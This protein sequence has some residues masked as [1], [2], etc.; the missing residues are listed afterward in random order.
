MT[1]SLD[2]A[3]AQHSLSPILA[4]DG[5]VMEP[6]C[7]SSVRSRWSISLSHQNFANWDAT[8]SSTRRDG[9]LVGF[10]QCVLD[11]PNWIVIELLN[12]EP[13]LASRGMA[14]RSFVC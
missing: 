5:T 7:T 1:Q 12:D 8:E 11:R 3:G 6:A 14:C 2:H 4:D 9:H 10:T 13:H